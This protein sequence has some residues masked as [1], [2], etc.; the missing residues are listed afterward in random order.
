MCGRFTLARG[1]APEIA[2]AFEL[3]EQPHLPGLAPRYNVAP[4]QAVPVI[5]I[6]HVVREGAAGEREAVLMRWG[7]VPHWGN[8]A[9][10]INARSETVTEKPVFRKSFLERRCLLPADGFFEWA[11]TGKSK[12]AIHFRLKSGGL[13]A[14]AGIWD[15]GRDKAGERVEACTILTAEANE[16]VRPYHDRM[17]VILRAADYDMWLNHSA[18]DVEALLKLLVPFPAGEMEAV[19]VGSRVNSAR[20]EGPE[21][22]AS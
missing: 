10:L 17:P 21:C 20:N 1:T 7:I 16:L 9:P 4:T 13:F 18:T 6:V 5:R 22:L 12:H 19:P 2:E 15:L 3:P 14:L 11:G 8:G